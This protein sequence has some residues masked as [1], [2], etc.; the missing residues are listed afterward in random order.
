MNVEQAEAA[1]RQYWASSRGTELGE[2]ARFNRMRAM[3]L[4]ELTAR[5]W[6]ELFLR[7]GG[8]IP[9]FKGSEREESP[10]LLPL[11]ELIDRRGKLGIKKPSDSPEQ[12]YRARRSA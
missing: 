11:L 10:V 5:Q 8:K 4:Y 6:R 2:A 9:R 1:I 3:L 12:Q 7:L